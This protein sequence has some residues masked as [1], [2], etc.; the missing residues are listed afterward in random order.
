MGGFRDE[1]VGAPWAG[2]EGE[3]VVETVQLYLNE[4]WFVVLQRQV[5]VNVERICGREQKSA[6]GRVD[7]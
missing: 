4:V 5:W 6:P 1:R 7:G 2:Q 3:I